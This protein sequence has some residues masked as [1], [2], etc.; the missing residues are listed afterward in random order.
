M[1]HPLYLVAQVGFLLLTVVF[2]ALLVRDIRKAMRLTAWDDRQ[3]RNFLLGIIATLTAWAI[4][5]SA[6]SLSGRMADFDMFPLNLMPVLLV[7]IIIAV[8]FIS[9]RKL[10]EVLRHIP[11]ENII[12]LQSFRFVVEV[13][14]WILFIAN[15]LPVQMSFEGRNF[16][17][18]AGF[19]APIVAVLVAK[20]LISKMGIIIWNIVCLALL[21]N[22]VIT[23]ILSTPSPWRVFMNEP[24]NYIVTYFPISWLPGFLVPLA[25]YLHFMSLRQMSQ[26]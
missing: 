16:D 2:I 13:L 8:V 21:L 1:E 22:I 9:S 17:I 24:A 26:R 20:G 5:V 12:R 3:K 25:Y 18:L 23:A 4:F 14:L 15:L 19:S 7:P 6:W 10:G 11:P